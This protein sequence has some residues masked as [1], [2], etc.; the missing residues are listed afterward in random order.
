MVAYPITAPVA[1]AKTRTGWSTDVTDS[2]N[3]HETRIT[4]LE[5]LI[6]GKHF[7]TVAGTVATSVAAAEAAIV[8]WNASSDA[9]ITWRNGYIYL[10]MFNTGHYDSAG[11][12]HVS[13]IRIRKS[14]NST[15][16]QELIFRRAVEVAGV[17]ANVSTFCD[18]G[19]VKN[20]SGA[21]IVSTPGM[22]IQRV[23]GAANVSLYGDASE[24]C[25]ISVFCLGLSANFAGLAARATAIT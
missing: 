4:A 8:S 25:G 22:T 14:V 18:F 16:A 2:C 11:S 7:Y 23:V 24:L 15:A 6:P 12:I 19:Y 21:D 20:A 17:G 13:T 10:V 9:S 1:G 5:A 3:D